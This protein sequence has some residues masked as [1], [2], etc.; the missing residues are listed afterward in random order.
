MTDQ[1]SIK[2][3]EEEIQALEEKL[4]ARKAEGEPREEKEVFREVLKEHVEHVKEAA[5]R[6]PAS[7]KPDATA[8]PGSSLYDYAAQI[9]KKGGA[10]A[11]DEHKEQVDALVEIA[12]TK[13]IAEAVNVARHLRN[14]HLLDDFHD[15]LIDEYYEKLVQA[16]EIS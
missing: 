7:G 2:S 12:L 16:R 13:G 14:P 3:L 9:E 6:E 4:A 1:E 10:E 11:E 15:A 8:V 5:E